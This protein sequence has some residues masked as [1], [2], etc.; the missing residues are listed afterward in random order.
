MHLN[1]G[2]RGRMGPGGL[3]LQT[4]G[5]ELFA[6]GSQEAQSPSPFSALTGLTL[7]FPCTQ[8]EDPWAE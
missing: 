4:Q 2:P 5:D 6:E 8:M 1:W 7:R 3:S